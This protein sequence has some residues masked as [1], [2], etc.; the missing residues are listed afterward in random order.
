MEIIN[1]SGETKILHDPRVI[2]MN[3]QYK[4]NVNYSSV[5]KG[6]TVWKNR[7]LIE[8]DISVT[9]SSMLNLPKPKFIYDTKE[10]PR[11]NLRRLQDFFKELFEYLSANLQVTTFWLISDYPH[12]C[13]AV[14]YKL[15]LNEI[16]KKNG[17]FLVPVRYRQFVQSY[18]IT[19][20]SDILRDHRDNTNFYTPFLSL[21]ILH[22]EAD[23]EEFEIV[24]SV[25]LINSL[26]SCLCMQ[27][28]FSKSDIKDTNVLLSYQPNI[29]QKLAPFIE[30]WYFENERITYD[31]RVRGQ[32]TVLR[33]YNAMRAFYDKN[34]VKEQFPD[35][36]KE[37]IIPPT[38]VKFQDL[39]T[40][41]KNMIK[42]HDETALETMDVERGDFE[43]KDT[44]KLEQIVSQTDEFSY[45]FRLLREIEIVL[46]KDGLIY[47]DDLLL[48]IIST[49]ANVSEGFMAHCISHPMDLTISFFPTV[50]GL[51][52]AYL[53][54]KFT[55][56]ES[57]RIFK[58]CSYPTSSSIISA[59]RLSE[60]RK[61]I[62]DNINQCLNEKTQKLDETNIEIFISY[63]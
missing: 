62:L 37:V 20:D 28:V 3:V 40:F 54:F 15:H 35:M 50:A 57:K 29:H 27:Y 58:N 55:E 12:R 61:L 6:V 18:C 51:A 21:S 43:D 34:E 5:E 23:I 7:R 59:Y 38:L 26:N 41:A 46:R 44:S 14:L 56:A 60:N 32:P 10:T 53:P 42:Y 33:I 9:L 2:F 25:A 30:D 49:C 8:S 47:H 39:V 52:V 48:R 63:F 31:N 16:W 11:D 45:W 36:F 4:M 19:K 1:L 24:N 22:P 13:M 17:L